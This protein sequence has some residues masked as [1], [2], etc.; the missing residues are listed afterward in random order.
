MAT[1]HELSA[2]VPQLHTLAQ[3]SSEG[4]DGRIYL[5]DMSAPATSDPWES[6]VSTAPQRLIAALR[7]GAGVDESAVVVLIRKADNGHSWLSGTTEAAVEA[8]RGAVGSVALERARHGLRCNIVVISPTTADSDVTEVLRYLLDT[9]R[10][11]YCT[12]TTVRLTKTGIKQITER[13]DNRPMR[14]L[15]TG[16]SGGIGREAAELFIQAGYRVL[17]TDVDGDGLARAAGQLG[18]DYHAADMMRP[19][20]I[21]RLFEL[22]FFE[23]GLDALVSCHGVQAAGPLEKL[24]EAII[25]KSM[26][27]NATSVMMLLREA[28]GA[29]A[30]AAPSR[31]AVVSS[32]AGIQAEALQ[33]AY[34]AAKFAVKGLVLGIGDLFADQ[35]TSVNVLCPGYVDTEMLRQVFERFSAARGEADSAAVIAERKAGV[36]VGR[37]GTAAEMAAALLVL[38]RLNA[39]GVTLIPT[40]GIGFL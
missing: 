23:P 1:V 19:A 40:G 20:D 12:A 30:L 38:C 3:R 27:I 6:W 22:P 9:A 24:D 4:L 34:C 37:F 15:V 7:G 10:S 17:L 36:P 32:H 11:G 33:T 18:A 29:L 13:R 26:T 5:L 16:A 14:A 28:R 31:V 21:G 35:D 8:L 2:A 25:R 39:T